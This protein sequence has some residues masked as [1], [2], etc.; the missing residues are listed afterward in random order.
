MKYPNKMILIAIALLGIVALTPSCG[1]NISLNTRTTDDGC[2]LVGQKLENGSKVYAGICQD[3]RY[4]AQWD[5]VQT[6]GTEVEV[7]FTRYKNGVTGVA[8]RSGDTWISWDEKSG[9][10]I[11][12]PPV[13]LQ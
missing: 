8:Y 12:Q 4:V 1:L 10:Q 13:V 2:V 7:R 9:V 6:D 5:A 11:G 3:G